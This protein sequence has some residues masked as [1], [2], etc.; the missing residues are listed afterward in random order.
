VTAYTA[1]MYP[2]RIRGVG[3]GFSWAVAFLI[4]AVLWPFVSVYLRETT[5]SFVAAFLL[6]PV[7]LVVMATI[8]WFYSPEHARKELDAISVLTYQ[9]FGSSL[10][11]ARRKV[12]LRSSINTVVAENDP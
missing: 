7:I 9:A 3:N 2:T 10:T 11:R 5:G 1:E 12:S 6:I 8:I 4:G